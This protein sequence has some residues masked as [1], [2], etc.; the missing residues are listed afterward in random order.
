MNP[1]RPDWITEDF[2]KFALADNEDSD[3]IKVLS[4]TS[5]PAVAAGNNYCSVLYRTKVGYSIKDSETVLSRSLIIKSPLTDVTD[6]QRVV[7]DAKFLQNECNFYSQILPKLYETTHFKFAPITYPCK[8]ENCLVMEDL[9]EEDYVM[10]DRLKLL[11]YEHCK[12]F[13][14]T[15]AK[16]HASTF[17]LHKVQPELVEHNGNEPVYHLDI[18]KSS[19]E[20]LFKKIYLEAIIKLIENLEGFEH[21]AAALTTH[22]DSLPQ[23]TLNFFSRQGKINVLNHGDCW[24]NNILFQ[25]K[26]GKITDTKMIDFQIR[27]YGSF[28]IDL[29]YFLL[30]SPDKEVREK[31]LNELTEVYRKTLNQRLAEF[32]CN[33]SLSEEDVREELLHASPWAVHIVSTYLLLILMEPGTEDQ[34]PP[35]E[36]HLNSLDINLNPKLMPLRSKT[37]NFML[38]VICKQMVGFGVLD[39][40]N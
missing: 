3:N 31:H 7:E 30:T 9:K 37:Y 28:S 5:E 18:P 22:I 26:N 38:P 40:L 35:S 36:E 2:L 29:M 12:A 11:D 15:L 25:I 34:S 32:G 21:L 1:T 13:L 8:I 14:V 39:F 6:I 4:Y 19:E 17:A 16:F 10:C 24:T 33:E 27:R 23:E 20:W